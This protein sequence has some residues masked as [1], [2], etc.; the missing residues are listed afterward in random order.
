MTVKSVVHPRTGQRFF[1][2]RNKPRV[3][4]PR[5]MFGTYETP[6]LP[7]PPARADYSPKALACIRDIYGNDQEG[8]CTIAASFHVAGTLLA[9][10]DAAVPA[11]L[12]DARAHAVY[13]QLTGGDDTGLDEETVLDFWQKNGLLPDGSCAITG[14][15]SVNASNW[16]QVCQSQWLFENLV[17]AVSLPD[18]WINPMP[19]ADHFIWD[20]AGPPNPDNGHAFAGVAFG[21][22]GVAIATWGMIGVITPRAIAKYAGGGSGGQLFSVLSQDSFSRATA[23]SASGFDY[24]QLQTDMAAYSGNQ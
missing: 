5:F 11:G 15:V 20:S 7:S 2:G 24:A 19:S 18:A 10:A 8:D 1:L 17:F 21:S 13:R 22:L 16:T 14:R 12:D 6:E 3:N 4:R 23:R 9:N